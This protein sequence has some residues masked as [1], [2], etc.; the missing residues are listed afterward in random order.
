MSNIEY[1]DPEIANDGQSANNWQ[2]G[3][4]TNTPATSDEEYQPEFEPPHINDYAAFKK[5]KHY[6]Q[7]FRPY[8]YQPF[9][10]WMYHPTQEP[11]IVKSKDE[12]IALGQEWS[13][14]PLKRRAD[15]TGK[16]LP[17]K[18]ETQRLA[19]VVAQALA[20]QQGNKPVD[21][22]AIAAIVAAVVAAIP[23]GADTAPVS[24]GKS[25]VAPETPEVPSEDDERKALLEL[26]EKEGVKTDKRWSN[27]RLKKEL[28]L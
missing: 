3:A 26:A 9:P 27:A 5:H 21:S 8:R 14:Q 15:M 11:R 25:E 17:V 12:V 28:G 18:S 13:P 6:K 10:A 20:S 24:P 19:E 16:S 2:P 7:Y 22:N 1:L 4:W 23:R